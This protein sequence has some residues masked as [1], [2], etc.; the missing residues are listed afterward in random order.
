MASSAAAGHL[1]EDEGGVEADDL[2]L[3]GLD[4]ELGRRQVGQ[5]REL[6]AKA[7]LVVLVVLAGIHDAAHFKAIRFGDARWK[8]MRRGDADFSITGKDRMLPR[9]VREGGRQDVPK[10]GK[11]MR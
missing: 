8:G 11:W 10:V 4:D 7:L 3:V 2:L 6:L 9:D 1:S 5:L